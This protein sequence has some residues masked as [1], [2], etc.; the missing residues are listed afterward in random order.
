LDTF[1]DPYTAQAAEN[2]ILHL[3]EFA[4]SA[5]KEIRRFFWPRLATEDGFHETNQERWAP[6]DGQAWDA[7]F[8]DF[9][10]FMT[11]RLQTMATYIQ[12]LRAV[13]TLSGVAVRPDGSKYLWRMGEYIPHEAYHR[14]KVLL[15]ESGF[16]DTLLAD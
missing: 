6:Y 5:V 10:R 1:A 8:A 2:T 13:G 16:E 7:F 14:L 3:V 9:V 11:P 4:Q 12:E 15:D